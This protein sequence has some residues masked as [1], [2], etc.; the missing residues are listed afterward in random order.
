MC[1][2]PKDRSRAKEELPTQDSARARVSE[3]QVLGSLG[4]RAREKAG[5]MRW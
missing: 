4:G 2:D 1:R 3:E 5:P